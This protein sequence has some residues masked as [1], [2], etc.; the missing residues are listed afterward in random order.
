VVCFDIMANKMFLALLEVFIALRFCESMQ[1][2]TRWDPRQPPVSYVTTVLREMPHVNKPFTQALEFTRDG[3]LL[4][5][6]SG[7]FPVGTPSYVRTLHPENGTTISQTTQGLENAFVE[8]I[9]LMG[10][11]PHWFASTYDERRAVEYD[12]NFNFVKAHDFPHVGWGLTRSPDNSSFIATDGSENLMYLDRNFNLV[13]QKVVSCLGY[14]VK[15]LNE[16]EMVDNFQGRGPTL[17]ANVYES[18][19]VLALDPISA[20]CVAAFSLNGLGITDPGEVSGFHV[21][22]GIAFNKRT[23]SLIVTGKNWD[24][25]FEV[26]VAPGD[27]TVFSDLRTVLERKQLAALLEKRPI[28]LPYQ[29]MPSRKSRRRMLFAATAAADDWGSY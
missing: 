16:L 5:E 15:G 3:T 20:Q 26:T 2:S 10:S 22:N 29:D 4:V 6:T 25:M 28:A 11:P 19:V 12:E 18:R 7:A 27:S 14:A 17:L 9:V 23:G 21:A 13:S 1:L 8:G 24:S